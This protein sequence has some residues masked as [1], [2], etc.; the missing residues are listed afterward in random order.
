MVRVVTAGHINWDVTLSVDALPEPDGEARITSQQRSGGGSAANVAAALAGMDVSTGLVGSIGS[1]EHGLLVRRE[2][3][4]AGV[5]CTH[6]IEVAGIETT[7]KY[8]IV[9]EGGE[10]M[11]LGNEGAN[12]T[13]APEDVRPEYVTG[14]EHL[15]LTSQRPETAA[16]LARIA[17]EAD[18]SVSFDPG[19]RL[20]E[21]DFSR[22]LAY[23][24]VVFL[25]DREAATILD[26]DLEHPSSELHGRVVVIKHGRRGARVDTTKGVYTHPGFGVESVDSTGSGD[27]FAA[28]FIATL[29]DSNDYERALEYANACGA[30]TAMAA[31]AR[32]AP[33]PE[34]VEAFLDERY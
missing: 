15:H 13:I 20:A 31:G 34:R 17:T 27:A 26:G 9:D 5:D 16:E 23:S 21:R 3:T 22:A 33:T 8:L 7:T 4:N 6:V 1:D 2:L 18:L 30:L 12:E 24:D 28:G 14:A 19:R 10:V 32:T 29:L 25:N 11:V